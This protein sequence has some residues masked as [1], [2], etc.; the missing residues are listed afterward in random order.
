M[1]NQRAAT[2]GESGRRPHLHRGKRQ[3]VDPQSMGREPAGDPSKR[4]PSMLDFLSRVRRVVRERRGI[5]FV[6]YTSLVLL[7]ALAAI[8][9]LSHIAG[10]GAN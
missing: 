7:I 9:L 6:E 2:A 1:K 4:T 5:V 8:T 3:H 10:S